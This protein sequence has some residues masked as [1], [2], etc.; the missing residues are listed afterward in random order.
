MKLQREVPSPDSVMLDRIFLQDE[1]KKF[2]KEKKEI[3]GKG[4]FWWHGIFWY[5]FGI[6]TIKSYINQKLS[7]NFKN[8]DFC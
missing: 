8:V 1:R 2:M 4:I 5:T 6:F 7:S 3:K